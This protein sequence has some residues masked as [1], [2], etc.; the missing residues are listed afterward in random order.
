MTDA[1]RFRLR[2]GSYR[3]PR[4]QYGDVAYC[5][6]RGQVTIRGL[7]TDLIPWPV[8]KRGRAKSL[9]IYK[10]LAKAV[11]REAAQ[12]VC[13]WWGVTAQTITKWRKALGVGPTTEGTSE[14]RRAYALEP[15]IT[16]ARRKAWPRALIPFVAPRLP[17][18][19]VASR[20]LDTSLRR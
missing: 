19:G 13:H 9:V 7:T 4:F 1:E 10:S 11:K 8:G 5:D 17:Q 16:E 15:P 18:P 20:D 6:V 14:L 3:T 2:F 12:A